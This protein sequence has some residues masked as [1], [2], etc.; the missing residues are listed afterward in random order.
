MF[1]FQPEIPREI[2][3][4]EP[5]GPT[6]LTEVDSSGRTPLQ[7]AVLYGRLDLVEL[8]LD[9]HTSEQ[10]C[11]PD[12]HGLFPVHT[13]A[14][15]GCSW[16]IDE[17]IKKCPDYYE[18]VDDRGRNLLHCAVEHNKETVV[19][20]ICQDEKFAMLL[21]ATDADGNTALHLAAKHGFPRIFSLLLQVN[22]PYQQGWPDC[23]RSWS[24]CA[25]IRKIALFPGKFSPRSFTFFFTMVR[26][27]CRFFYYLFSFP[28]SLT[29]KIKNANS[30]FKQK[31]KQKIV[32]HYTPTLPHSH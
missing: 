16:I 9:G 25:A 18:L 7:Y 11:I 32:Q 22:R 1:I 17:L 28:T 29:T 31:S 24:P 14:M 23:I 5:V 19:R 26:S 8:F 30:V 6:L 21:N 2:L 13:A 4:W 12:N 3:K 27:F 20:H 10:A 15:V